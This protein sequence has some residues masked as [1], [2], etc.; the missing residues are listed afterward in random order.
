VYGRAS[1]KLGNGVMASSKLAEL[2]GPRSESEVW[3]GE[4]DGQK[5]L[6]TI[7]EIVIAPMVGLPLSLL[8]LMSPHI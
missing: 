6:P 3:L 1:R 8:Y 5:L 2:F 4:K 7:G